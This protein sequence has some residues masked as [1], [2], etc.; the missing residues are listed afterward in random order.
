MKRRLLLSL[1]A[2]GFMLTSFVAGPPHIAYAQCG[3][4]NDPPCEPGGAEKERK[5]KPT[6]VP[7]QNTPTSVP[8]NTP[9]VCTESTWYQ[10]ADADGYGNAYVS[11][12]ACS[13]PAGYAA[14]LADCNDTNASIRPG[15]TEICGDGIDQDC[16]GSDTTCAVA[17]AAPLAVFC[18][19]PDCPTDLPKGRLPP[20]LFGA[21]ILV[22]G[23]LI[24]LL[25]PFI[26][27]SF[28]DVSPGGTSQIRESPIT[29][30]GVPRTGS[31]FDDTVGKGTPGDGDIDPSRLSQI[32]ESPTA[33]TG[34]ALGAREA[35]LNVREAALNVREAALKAREAASRSGTGT[36]DPL[37]ELGTADQM[38]LQQ[39]M[40]RLTK[41]MDLLSN[42]EKKASD[43]ASAIAGNLK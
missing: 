13:A 8:T 2:C 22:L 4:P 27:R 6:P 25:L 34:S 17:A 32:R 10:D 37:S 11:L 26:L 24:G 16:S 35:A 19:G 15:A 33:E 36:T 40:E 29:G 21:G 41:A 38:R 30:S 5:T 31:F 23:I 12:P 7:P 28:F 42:L 18:I 9:V 14:L 3:G 39:A 43:T 1:M 20:W